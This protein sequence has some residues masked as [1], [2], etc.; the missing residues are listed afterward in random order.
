MHPIH[1]NVL[2]L[3]QELLTKNNV[4]I[5]EPIRTKIEKI[6]N[7]P[8]E[9]QIVTCKIT[10]GAGKL[11][12]SKIGGLKRH[13]FYHP[14]RVNKELLDEELP[15]PDTVR[16]AKK[17][18]EET[19]LFRSMNKSNPNLVGSHGSDLHKKYLSI[20]T[21]Y[22]G[23]GGGDGHGGGVRKWDSAS[24]SSGISSGDLSSPCDCNE[25]DENM[26]LLSA[27]SMAHENHDELC[28]SYYVSQVG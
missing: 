22:N 25:N 26:K 12:E 2:Y 27:S 18:F 17:L 7:Q 14:I 10:G 20:D 6:S 15:T 1:S 13:F 19:L 9:S 5:I 24:L 16:N 28:E 4:V 23:T 3:S 8:N 11:T 21:S